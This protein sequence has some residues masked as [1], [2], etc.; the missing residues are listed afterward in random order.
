VFEVAGKTSNTPNTFDQTIFATYTAGL[1]GTPA[2]AGATVNLYLFDNTGNTPLQHNGLNVCNPCSFPIGGANPRKRSINID[3]LISAK[4]V[5]NA[6][7]KLGSAILVV[8]GDAGNVTLQSMLVNSHNSAF[9]ITISSPSIMP[10][11]I[12]ETVSIDLEP[13]PGV[14]TRLGA[15]PT[16]A[17]GEVRFSMELA[18]AADV[19][20]TIFDVA[21]R[22][23]ATVYKGRLEAGISE[24]R[25]NGDGSSGPVSGGIYFARLSSPDGSSQARLVMRP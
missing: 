23:I 5:F 25:W 4:G 14:V 2:G 18:R 17:S 21:G 24:C 3:D 19:E 1:A 20:L 13:R 9:D 22:K 8:S 11:Q 16:P 10:V 15:S 6:G 7:V 12:S